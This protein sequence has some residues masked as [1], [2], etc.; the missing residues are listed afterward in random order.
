MNL[1]IG[2]KMNNHYWIIVDEN[3]S[4]AGIDI[5]SGGYPFS[6]R[7]LQLAQWYRTKE[8]ADRFMKIFGEGT[9]YNKGYKIREVHIRVE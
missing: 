1:G 5:A 9:S 7:I 3:E 2:M 4:F 8:D 6:T